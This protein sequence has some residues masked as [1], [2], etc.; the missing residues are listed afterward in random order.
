[1]PFFATHA[2]PL[3][4]LLTERGTEYC[5]SPD[6]PEY[7]LDLA[8]ETIDHPRTKGKSPQT[9]GIVERFHKTMLNEFYQLTFRKKSYTYETVPA[10]LVSGSKSDY[11]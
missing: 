3:S 10:W 7:E 8:I 4:P 11:I 2:V 9:K 6:R 1:V 5:G